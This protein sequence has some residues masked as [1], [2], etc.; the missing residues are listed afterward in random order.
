LGRASALAALALLAGCKDH[1]PVEPPT[2]SAS[3]TAA[4]APE[5][6]A[7]RP[8]RR[9]YLGRTAARCEIYYLDTSGAS[10]PFPTPCPVDLMVG[11]RI[12]IA[13]K[14]CMR[15][16]ND[17]ERVEPVVCPD[18]LTNFEMK[19]RGESRY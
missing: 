18:P 15:E 5:V 13:G 8:T 19:D 10:T 14:T 16:G 9:Y 1:A 7:R 4:P 12:R 11:E 17:P 3:A 2:P 6:S